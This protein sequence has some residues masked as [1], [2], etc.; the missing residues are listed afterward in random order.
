MQHFIQKLRAG[1]AVL[2]FLFS[3]TR[4]D[5]VFIPDRHPFAVAMQWLAVDRFHGSLGA[6]VGGI[7]VR[8]FLCVC[9]LKCIWEV[10]TR[11]C[12]IV[13][14]CVDEPLNS[15]SVQCKLYMFIYSSG[16]CLSQEP[17][18]SC[19]R[20][21]CPAMSPRNARREFIVNYVCHKSGLEPGDQR[22]RQSRSYC[23]TRVK[24]RAK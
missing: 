1:C 2:R 13:P 7:L 9:T 5:P 22:P 15:V 11:C 21:N 19:S 24:S 3:H 17:R 6:G 14:I 20:L 10:R 12:T 16:L 18:K 4:F 8:L 23:V